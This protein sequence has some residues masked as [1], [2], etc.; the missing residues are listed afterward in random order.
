M[1]DDDGLLLRDFTPE[2]E[3]VVPVTRLA[4]PCHWVVDAH[5]HLD[6]IIAAHWANRP[7]EELLDVMDQSSVRIV[8]D[9][10]GWQ[11]S[12]A[13]QLNLDRFKQRAPERF[14]H[15]G[16]VEWERWKQQGNSFGDWAAK[17][18]RQQAQWGAQ[19]LKIWK[20][21]GLQVTDETGLLVAV[22]DPRLDPLWA[23]AASLRLPVCIHVADPVAFFKPRDGRNERWEELSARPQCHVPSPPYPSFRSILEAFERLVMRHPATTFIGAHVGCYPENLQWVSSLMD[24][25][26]NFYVDISNRISELGRQPY[27]ARRFI[28]RHADRILFGTDCPPDAEIYQLYFR[29]LETDDEYFNYYPA[30]VPDQGRWRVYGLF[31]EPDVLKRVYQSNALRLLR[32]EDVDGR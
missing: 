1:T 23:E 6:P 2:S 21:L 27:S 10:V 17:A 3:L 15:F 31:L 5:N 13:L 32:L 20:T 7:V 16:G 24:R 18:L 26:P 22:D 29:F 8:V 25:A 19:G 30:P 9:M 14:V 12:R 11:G 28:V 4:G